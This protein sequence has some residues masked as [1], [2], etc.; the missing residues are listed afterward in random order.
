MKNAKQ[1]ENRQSNS[2]GTISKDIDTCNWN[3]RRRKR[4]EQKKKIG[5]I[6]KNFSKLITDS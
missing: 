6:V 2:C 5:K 3:I 1:H 4:M